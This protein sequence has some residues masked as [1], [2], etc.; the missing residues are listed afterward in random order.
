MQ[1]IF[2]T[3]LFRFMNIDFYFKQD[4]NTKIRDKWLKRKAVMTYTF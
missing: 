2:K 1:F 4:K 3:S